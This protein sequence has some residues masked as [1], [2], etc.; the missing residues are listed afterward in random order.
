MNPAFAVQKLA[1]SATKCNH[2]LV[3]GL[4]NCSQSDGLGKGIS[5]AAPYWNG[6]LHQLGNI[7]SF[8]MRTLAL[9]NDNTKQEIAATCGATEPEPLRGRRI[10]G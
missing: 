5:E 7:G 4:L 1:E 9:G 2:R 10:S 6:Q 3:F 8:V